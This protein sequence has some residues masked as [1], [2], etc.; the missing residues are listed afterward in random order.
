MGESLELALLQKELVWHEPKM[1]RD[2]FT[3][4][5]A[6]LPQGTDLAILPEMF[7]TGFTMTPAAIHPDESRL[8]LDWMC[9]TAKELGLAL[10]GSMIYSENGKYT[11]RLFFVFPDG[12]FT[13][14][15]KKH[16]FTLAGEDHLYE[17]GLS[18]VVLEYG[19]FRICPLICYDLR[20][21]LW[22]RNTDA[23]DILLIVANWPE[24]R[25]SAWDTLL[26]AR[27]IE[28]M[29]Y[30]VGVNRIGRDPNGNEYP[31]HSAVYDCLGNQMVYSEKSESFNVTL[32][33]SH[34]AEVRKKLPFLEDRD[35][36]A[37][38]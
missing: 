11:N 26:K 2:V 7:S 6:K 17:A 20:F 15:D 23:Y 34:I 25:I 5:L 32:T 13:Y 14:Y 21:P 35:S 29:S 8:T 22:A 36:F 37:I 3:D 33:R 38:Q 27:A 10:T 1:N 31:G 9:V 19:G 12:H 28:N 4:E 18:R 24:P 30:C 16:L